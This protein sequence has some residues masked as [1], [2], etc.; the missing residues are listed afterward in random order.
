MFCPSCANQTTTE[1]K[2]C[3]KCG[4]NLEGTTASLLEQF[5]DGSHSTFQRQERALDVFGRVAFSGLGII[6]VL[7]VLGIIYAVLENMVLSGR[8]PYSGILLVALIVFAA[9]GLTYVILT[10]VLK[11]RRNKQTNPEQLNPPKPNL[12]LPPL[13]TNDLIP[14]PSVVENT[15][16]KL[17]AEARKK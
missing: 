15:T 14:V 6:A 3:R 4:M 8:R 13:D 10:E 7:G 1:Q 17:K 5:P 9:L 2:F 16:R 11:E 12:E